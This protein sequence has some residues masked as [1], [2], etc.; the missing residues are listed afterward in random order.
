[1][2]WTSLLG[3]VGIS[4]GT[5]RRLCLPEVQKKKFIVFCILYCLVIS[6]S[7]LSCPAEKFNFSKLG[8]LIVNDVA[9]LLYCIIMSF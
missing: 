8:P 7:I 9:F 6:N 4:G 5:L 2:P 1:M 3:V